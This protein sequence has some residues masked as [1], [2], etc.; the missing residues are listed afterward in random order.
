MKRS[1]KFSNETVNVL[2]LLD[3]MLY[4][5]AFSHNENYASKSISSLFVKIKF[6]SFNT[7]SYVNSTGKL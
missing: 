6:S 4:E 3:T 5:D 7:R 1:I 2:L